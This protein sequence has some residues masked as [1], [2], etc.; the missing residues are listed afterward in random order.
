MG[1]SEYLPL[2]PLS[3]QILIALADCSRHGY[4]V[5]K[6]VE[7]Q[8]GRPLRSSTGT[9]YLAI[10]RLE[11]AQLIEE[12]ETITA[13][14]RRRRHYRLTDLGRD[15]AAAEASRLWSL[16]EVAQGKRLLEGLGKRLAGE[17]RSSGG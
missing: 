13:T 15:V 12:D 4:G 2:T 1:I 7:Q 6:E 17:A 5:I 8:E 10:Q 14:G 16:L 3:F 11:Q 9:V